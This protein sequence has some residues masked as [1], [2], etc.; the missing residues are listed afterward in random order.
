YSW[1]RKRRSYRRPD[2]ARLRDH[3]RGCS[4]NC[5]G[6]RTRSQCGRVPAP[7]A[8]RTLD[9]AYRAIL[10]PCGV[11]LEALRAAPAGIRVP[12]VT[13]YRKFAEAAEHGRF[14]VAGQ[15]RIAMIEQGRRVE[16]DP[17]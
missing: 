3:P 12:L 14:L 5:R 11:T 8:A 7:S 16:L 6:D 15:W 9:A 2:R 13:R 4:C 17:A 1:T 10:A